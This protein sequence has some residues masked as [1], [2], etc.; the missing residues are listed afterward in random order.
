[1]KLLKYYAK[2]NDLLSIK[3][4]F[5]ISLFLLSYLQI[6]GQSAH[7]YALEADDAYEKGFFREAERSYLKVLDKKQQPEKKYN[8][9]NAIYQQKRYEEAIDHYKETIEKASDDLTKALAF[10]NLGNAYYFENELEE[11]VEAYK[12]A[13]RIRPGDLATKFNL[14]KVQK[15][16]MQQQAQQQNQQQQQKKKDQKEQD[17]NNQQ[18]NQQGEGAEAAETEQSPEGEERQMEKTDLNKEEAM[19]LLEIIEEEEKKVLEQQKSGK[20][21]KKRPSKDW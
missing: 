2:I 8:L 6:I 21:D 19:K 1:M 17:Q 12:K 20:S 9:G 15:K 7:G 16:L 5:F 14:A 18:Q 10:H 13:L 11:S 3:V 4:G